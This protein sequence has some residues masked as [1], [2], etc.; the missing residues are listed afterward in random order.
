[1]FSHVASCYNSF[2]RLTKTTFINSYGKNMNEQNK[3]EPKTPLLKDLQLEIISWNQI[4]NS[5]LDLSN[6]IQNSGFVPDLI[7]GISRGGWIPARIFSDLLGNSNLDTVT[8]KFYVGISETKLEPKITQEMYS[9]VEGKKILLV[10]DLVDSG[11]SLSL[12][13]SY[14]KN[15][16]ASE[17]KTVTLYHKPGSIIVPNYFIKKT[18]AWIVFPWDHKE[19]V[20]NLFKKFQ[21]FGNS[22]DDIKEKLISFGFNKK[23]INQICEETC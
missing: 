13:I 11:K 9:S 21:T 12:V 18:M 16:G 17:V 22:V 20:R 6:L 10:D 23:I 4:Y 2:K 8:T 5:L 19:N 1:M 15:K 3:T 14:L 7:V